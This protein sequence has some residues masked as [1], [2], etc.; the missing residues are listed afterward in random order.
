MG[1]LRQRPAATLG[2][3]SRLLGPQGPVAADDPR[4]LF[5]VTDKPQPLRAH[6]L[7]NS[8]GLRAAHTCCRLT[9]VAPLPAFVPLEDLGQR[10]S[11]KAD[12]VKRTQ[13]DQ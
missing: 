2:V 13:R 5:S 8:R 9:L 4:C 10:L 3:I 12:S 6:S 11:E 7:R 1:G